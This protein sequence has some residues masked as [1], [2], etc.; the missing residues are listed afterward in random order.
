[1]E[2][3]IENNKMICT[4]PEKDCENYGHCCACVTKHRNKGNL[5]HCLRTKENKESRREARKAARS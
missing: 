3:T 1:M 4:C 5:P 2:C